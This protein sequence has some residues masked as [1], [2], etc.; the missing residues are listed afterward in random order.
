MKTR[1]TFTTPVSFYAQTTSYDPDQG[2]IIEWTKFESALSGTESIDVFWCEWVGSYGEMKM[3][4]QAQGIGES[5]RVRMP[6]IPELYEKLRTQRVLIAKNADVN[7]ISNSQPVITCP[8]AY[9]VWGGVDNVR[10]ENKLL[11]FNVRRYEVV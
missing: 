8:N 1:T 4:A 3:S 9:M 10:E 7:V 5:A 11:E 2:S 6:F